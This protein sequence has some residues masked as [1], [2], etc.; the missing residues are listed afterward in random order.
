MHLSL[1]SD[2]TLSDFLD[3][4][5]CRFPATAGQRTAARQHLDGIVRGLIF[6]AVLVSP[7]ALTFGP[8]VFGHPHEDLSAAEMRP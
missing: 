7:F 1:L 2:T 8:A 6:A 5:G 3:D 4:S